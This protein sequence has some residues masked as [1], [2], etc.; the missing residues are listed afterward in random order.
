VTKILKASTG[1]LARGDTAVRQQAV[2][3]L[4]DVAVMEPVA[5]EIHEQGGLQPLWREREAVLQIALKRLA[6]R[7]RQRQ[8]AGLVELARGDKEPL[9]AGV[10]IAQVQGQRLA[11]TQ[12]RAVKQS[13]HGGDGVGPQ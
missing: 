4:V 12:A 7:G 5:A 13:Q 8:P 2:E 9:F 11:N 1:V 3:V 6:D 10:E